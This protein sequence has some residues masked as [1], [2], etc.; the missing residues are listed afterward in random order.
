MS[1]IKI[2]HLYSDIFLDLP[3]LKNTDL[4]SDERFA[5][6]CAQ[7]DEA[8][9][10]PAILKNN[11]IIPGW[12]AHKLIGNI[13]NEYLMTDGKWSRNK[14]ILEYILSAEEIEK[15]N[16]HGNNAWRKAKD[17]DKF[18]LATK[19]SAANWLFPVWDESD[20]YETVDEY[21]DSL[22]S[23]DEYPDYVWGVDEITPSLVLDATEIVNQ[24][25]ENREDLKIN[26]LKGFAE[27]EK[28]VDTFAKLNDSHKTWR[29][30][31]KVVVLLNKK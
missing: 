12:W 3:R 7:L 16:K 8:Q 31:G 28:A 21:L 5:E 29:A 24:A 20:F 26:H 25:I 2:T 4:F 22:E 15:L 27:F 13:F 6:I 11:R 17:G 19:V 9:F 1:K 23:E 30:T 18:N 10:E 14:T